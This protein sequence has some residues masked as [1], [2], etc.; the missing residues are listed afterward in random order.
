[1]GSSSDAVLAVELADALGVDERDG[2]VAVRYAGRLERGQRGRA[3]L[4]RR[5]DEIEL[6]RSQR[7]WRSPGA[8][9][10]E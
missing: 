6:D 4:L 1:M 2:Q 8:W 5:V 9:L 10:C 7:A 3:Q